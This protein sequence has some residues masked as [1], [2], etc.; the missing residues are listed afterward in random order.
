MDQILCWWSQ[1]I[2]EVLIHFCL[3]KYFSCHQFTKHV[4]KCNFQLNFS[5]VST[6]VIFVFRNRK[7]CLILFLFL[8]YFISL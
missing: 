6:F 3:H 1:L 5:F 8:S 7:Q 2:L 4:L